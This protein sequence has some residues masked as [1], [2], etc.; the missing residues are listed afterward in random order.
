MWKN[1]LIYRN[2]L[3]TNKD[4]T[5]GI[6]IEFDKARKSI[7]ED[8]LNK[9]YNK[10]VLSN[11]WKLENDETIYD[12]IALYSPLGGEAISDIL[13]DNNKSWD[14]IKYVCEMIKSFGGIATT[15]CGAHVHIGANILNNNMKY[16]ERLIKLWI[17]YENI[18]SRFCYGEETEPRK[19]LPVFASSPYK[20]IKQLYNEYYDPKGEKLNLTYEEFIKNN[21][22]SLGLKNLSLSLKGLDNNY[23]KEKYQN[24]DWKNNKTIEFRGGNGTLNH[25]IWQNYINLYIKLLMCCLDDNKDWELINKKFHQSLKNQELEIFDYEKAI[26]FCN[27]IFNNDLDKYNFMIQYIKDNSYDNVLPKIKKKTI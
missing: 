25:I 6:E 1:N 4:I 9:A 15:K 21:K 17:I 24:K 16:Y 13:K 7:I 27:F 20:Y 5:F 11:I 19:T 22:Y 14:D 26:E 18:I 12:G 10:Q 3:E 8:L 2:N 23:L